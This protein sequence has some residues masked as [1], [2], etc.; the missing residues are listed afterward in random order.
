MDDWHPEEDFK[1]TEDCPVPAW[2]KPSVNDPDALP[3][4]TPPLPQPSVADTSPIA[5][6]HDYTNEVGGDSGSEFFVPS[7]DWEG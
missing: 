6:Q 3:K 5:P 1:L 4:V 2:L 7:P